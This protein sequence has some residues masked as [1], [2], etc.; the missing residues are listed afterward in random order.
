MASLEGAS[1]ARNS[2]RRSSISCRRAHLAWWDK[3]LEYKISSGSSLLTF[4]T[5]FG[6]VDYLPALPYTRQPV[7]NQWDI[8]IFMLQLLRKRYSK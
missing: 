5:E 4:L 3:V 6:P 1:A 2:R 8:N 7:A